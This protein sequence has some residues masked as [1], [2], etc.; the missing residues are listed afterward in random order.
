MRF[1]QLCAVAIAATKIA[2]ASACKCVK[3]SLVLGTLDKPHWNWNHLLKAI[4][5][6]RLLLAFG[7]SVDGP[8]RNYFRK[9]SQDCPFWV[10]LL[11]GPAKPRRSCLPISPLK[12]DH[13][14][15]PLSRPSQRPLA[16]VCEQQLQPNPRERHQPLW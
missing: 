15:L 11:Q 13:S 12:L 9:A 14:R 3:Y 5:T 6:R 7:R 16:V 1:G 2:N 10:S 8:Q 4:G